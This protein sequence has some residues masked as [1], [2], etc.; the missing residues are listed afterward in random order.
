LHYVGQIQPE[1]FSVIPDLGTLLCQPLLYIQAFECGF[2]QRYQHQSS[3]RCQ[4][5]FTWMSPNQTRIALCFL[6]CSVRVLLLFGS[7]SNNSYD[8]LLCLGRRRRTV[9]CPREVP[10]V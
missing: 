7:C 6:L 4:Y 2:R 10:N 1:V 8:T 9:R 3:H 5:P